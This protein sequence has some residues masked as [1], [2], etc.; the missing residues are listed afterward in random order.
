MAQEQ[1]PVKA[2]ELLM[3][4][5]RIFTVCTDEIK[6]AQVDQESRAPLREKIERGSF[7]QNLDILSKA[8]LSP[9]ASDESIST[10]RAS[11]RQQRDVSSLRQLAQ[12]NGNFQGYF[13][14]IKDPG[15]PESP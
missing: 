1:K 12:L 15:T 14:V 10:A 2:K 11:S 4:N 6:S 9:P 5:G 3:Q 13:E 8:C 7:K